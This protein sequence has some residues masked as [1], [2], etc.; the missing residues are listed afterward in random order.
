MEIPIK[1]IQKLS[2]LF[3]CL[4]FES[5]EEVVFSVEQ[6]MGRTIYARFGEVWCLLW[7]SEK[8]IWRKV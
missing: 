2:K 8:E 5:N 1:A 7:D 3:E 4:E 6:Y